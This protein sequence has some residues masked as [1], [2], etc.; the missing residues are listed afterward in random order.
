MKNF[1]R[2]YDYEEVYM[3]VFIYILIII[4]VTSFS[5]WSYVDLK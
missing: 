3:H 5:I 2:I 1:A 4:F